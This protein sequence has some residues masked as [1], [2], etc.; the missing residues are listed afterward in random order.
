MPAASSSKLGKLL[1]QHHLKQ[2]DLAVALGYREASFSRKL[3]VKK[4]LQPEAKPCRI[5]CL[6]LHL[7]CKSL[8]TLFRQGDATCSSVH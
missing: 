7:P 8:P 5:G 3:N 2:I 4:N 6:G 1:K